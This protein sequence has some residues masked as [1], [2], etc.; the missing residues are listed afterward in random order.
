SL[1]L[2]GPGAGQTMAIGI[3]DEKAVGIPARQIGPFYALR[4]L[5]AGDPLVH[6]RYAVADDMTGVPIPATFLT[7]NGQPGL[8]RT[9]L[10]H[11]PFDA[12]PR[13]DKQ[14]NFAI[15]SGHAL[16][17]DSAYTWSGVLNVPSAGSY[18]LYLQNLGCFA[19]LTLDGKKVVS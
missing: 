2:I 10:Q 5:T 15:S 6:L 13:V 17:A 1:A 12:A 8:E 14:I 4:K 11:A 19:S 9:A 18:W 7:H 3:P 16:S